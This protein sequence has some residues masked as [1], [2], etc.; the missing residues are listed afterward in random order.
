M[1]GRSNYQLSCSLNLITGLKSCLYKLSEIKKQ[2]AGG[3]VL[4]LIIEREWIL[5]KSPLLPG[6]FVVFQTGVQEINS[7]A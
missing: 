1:F 2:A 5:N 6:L 7:M 3:R 4:A